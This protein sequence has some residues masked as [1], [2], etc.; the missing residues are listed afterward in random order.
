MVER[1]VG[2]LDRLDVASNLAGIERNG[3]PGTEQSEQDP[4]RTLDIT[5]MTGHP[6]GSGWRIFGRA[7]SSALG[8]SFRYNS[9]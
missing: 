7:Q 4:D 6:P 5:F 8:K 1:M 2:K 3:V 9:Q